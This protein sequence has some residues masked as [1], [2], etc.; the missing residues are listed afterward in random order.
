MKG[1]IIRWAALCLCLCLLAGMIPHTVRAEGTDNPE[2]EWDEEM[3]ERFGWEAEVVKDGQGNPVLVNGYPLRTVRAGFT[4]LSQKD[5]SQYE[6]DFLDYPFFRP[7]TEYDGNLAV[8]SLEMALSSNRPKRFRDVPEEGFDPSLNLVAGTLV[9]LGVFPGEDVYAYTFATPAALRN[10]PE[11]GFENIYNIM[12]PMDLVPQV[13]PADWG[14][15]RY[16]NDLYLPV[17]EKSI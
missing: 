3:A 10:V 6:V 14:F 7:A 16:G 13:L 2:T 17:Q 9:K 1:R 15:G 4:N 11:K 5:S 8:M 12:E